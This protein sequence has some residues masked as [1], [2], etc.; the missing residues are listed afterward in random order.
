MLF[1]ISMRLYP[2]SVTNK[3]VPSEVTET[4]L[5]RLLA[6]AVVNLLRDIH[7]HVRGHIGLAQYTSADAPLLVGMELKIRTRS[8][9]VSA[10]N[11]WPFCS[12]TP[13]GPRSEA[14]V[15][16][17]PG[18][19]REV[20]LLCPTTTSGGCWMLV[21][22]VFQ[23]R[24][25]LLSVSATARWVPS[26]AIAVGDRIP[27][28][29]GVLGGLAG[30]T[31]VVGVT[32]VLTSGGMHGTGKV[33]TKSGWPSTTLAVPTQAGQTLLIRQLGGEPRELAADVLV[34]HHAVVDRRGSHHIGIHHEQRVVH[35]C[36]TAHAPQDR[37]GWRYPIP[38]RSTAGRSPG[39]RPDRCRSLYSRRETAAA[40]QNDCERHTSCF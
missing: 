1:Q 22:I 7:L 36:Q 35:I 21:G 33:V 2:R 5:S 15:G 32:D 25:R 9:C 11:S 20:K 17:V 12:Q 13:C 10:T 30:Q 38:N 39:A 31:G 18:K 26:E 8:F 29:V 3:C 4:G 14:A 34:D 27:V 19:V 23:M 6:A 24:M 37:I 16:V 40:C 28:A